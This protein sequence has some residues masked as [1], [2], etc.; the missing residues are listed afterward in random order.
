LFSRF[1]DDNDY[2][3]ESCI[4]LRLNQLKSSGSSLRPDPPLKM[5][6]FD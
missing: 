1:P 3:S 6:P 4:F 2:S 5:P